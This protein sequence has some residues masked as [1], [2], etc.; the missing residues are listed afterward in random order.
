MKIQ[1][2]ERWCWCCCRVDPHDKEDSNLKSHTVGRINTD[3]SSLGCIFLANN[4]D[5]LGYIP[6]PGQ[7]VFQSYLEIELVKQMLNDNETFFDINL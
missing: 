1:M 4:N 7:M 3:V 5:K 6:E 2:K